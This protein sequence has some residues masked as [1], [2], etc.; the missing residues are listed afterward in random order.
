MDQFLS[1]RLWQERKLL[2]WRP[3]LDIYTTDD[4][5]A[6]IWESNVPQS[7][8]DGLWQTVCCCRMP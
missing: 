8:I 6:V 2:F 4:I 5:V 1:L 7:D 3:Q